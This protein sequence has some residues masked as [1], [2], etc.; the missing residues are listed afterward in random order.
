M[1]VYRIVIALAV[2]SKINLARFSH[3]S[4]QEAVDELEKSLQEK[5]IEFKI[6]SGG[7]EMKFLNEFGGE[8]AAVVCE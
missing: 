5:G 6:E 2:N 1:S 3:P 8:F 4:E 7:G